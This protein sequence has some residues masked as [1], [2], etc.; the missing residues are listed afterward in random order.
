[1]KKH[2]GIKIALIAGAAGNRQS[3]LP[4][5]MENQR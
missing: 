2:K 5:E 3:L 1:M 4:E